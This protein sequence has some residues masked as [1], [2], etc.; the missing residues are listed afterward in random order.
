VETEEQL[1]F[2]K[3]EGCDEIQGYLMGRPR[4]IEE[5]SQWIEN[6]VALNRSA[7]AVA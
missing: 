4:P 2:L 1:A 6:G 5:Y 7:K 3:R